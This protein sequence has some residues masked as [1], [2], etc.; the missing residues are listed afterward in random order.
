[1]RGYFLIIFF[2]AI[3]LIAVVYGAPSN[4]GGSDPEVEV[5][6]TSEVPPSTSLLPLKP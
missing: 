1:M 4:S 6:T 2:L 5:P 3:V